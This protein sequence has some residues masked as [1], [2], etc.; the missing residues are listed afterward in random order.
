[1]AGDRAA[2]RKD[3]GA[4]IEHFARA[5]SL[6]P[7]NWSYHYRLGAAAQSAG[8]SELVE[9]HLSEAVRLDPDQAEPRYLLGTWC[10]RNNQPGRAAEQ[11]AA[12]ASIAPANRQ[13][14][15]GLATALMA[16]GDVS[17]GWRVLEPL[18][19]SA[20]TKGVTPLD[21]W[22]ASLYQRIAPEI[23]HEEK[24]LAFVNRVAGA[25]GLP[26]GPTGGAML[27]FSAATLLDRLRRYDEAFERARLAN[28]L[29][30]RALR[31]HD[32]A[33]FSAEVSAKINYFSRD[34][35]AALPR[36]AHGS[37][38]P[39]FVVGMPRSGTSLVEEILG[40]HPRVYGAGE[41]QALR[42][43]A[44]DLSAAGGRKYPGSLAPASDA[45]AGRAAA[46][47]LSAVDALAPGAERVIDKQPFN[48]LLLGLVELLFPE[49]RV[50]HCVRD[51]LDTCLSC[52]MTNFE[53]ANAFKF[54]LGHL[55]SYYRD[56]HR[57]MVHWKS[58]LGV[59]I[60]DVRY[61]DVVANL[62][63]QTRRM[64]EFLDLPWDERCLRFHEN[65]RVV[66]TASRDQVRRP[67]YGS[68]V[69]RWRRYEKHLRPLLEALGPAATP[70]AVAR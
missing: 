52:Y 29:A 50:I 69:G 15:V 64:L 68:S 36:A 39:V 43:V 45:E 42:L 10:F 53:Q 57:L 61:E 22:V 18:V 51:P 16:A 19:A 9:R 6:E 60:L 1:V 56:Y 54:D 28:D 26:P 20:E 62:E 4:A 32:P 58:V 12:A 31:R 2:A 44:R 67:V 3:Y 40:S 33:A 34:R 21:R 46:Q 14:A 59:P 17:G 49:C 47:Y 63:G 13:Y 11:L 8:R 41:L 35:L 70:G 27:Q 24:A 5:V 38:R 65:L 30:A 48:F 7:G 37:R 25:P 66:H 23:G 55:G